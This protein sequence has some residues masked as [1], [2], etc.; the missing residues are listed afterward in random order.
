MTGLVACAAGRKTTNRLRAIET[1]IT[2]SCSSLCPSVARQLIAFGRL[3]LVPLDEAL[4]VSLCRKTTNRLRAIETASLLPL[5]A[6]FTNV[7][8]QLIAFGR[9][10]LAL[11]VTEH[12]DARRSQD[13]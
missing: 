5:S 7:A 8:R 3:K 13:N 2:A 9:L 1:L 6:V 11:A 4:V 12:A 10:K